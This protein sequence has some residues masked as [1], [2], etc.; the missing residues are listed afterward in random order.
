[1]MKTI[2]LFIIIISSFNTFSADK[3]ALRA[4]NQRLSE[5][6]ILSQ[7]TDDHDKLFIYKTEVGQPG[8]I[9]QEDVSFQRINPNIIKIPIPS[10]LELRDCKTPPFSERVVVQNNLGQDYIEISALKLQNIKLSCSSQDLTNYSFISYK[11]I[12]N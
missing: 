10:G 6:F 5:L 9:L 11:S 1:M 2:F 7:S 8:F 4:R 12:N 3:D